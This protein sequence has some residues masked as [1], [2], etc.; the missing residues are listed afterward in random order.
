MADDFESLHQKLRQLWYPAALDAA[1]QKGLTLL[2]HAAGAGQRQAVKLL[3]QR[4]AAVA[5][6]GPGGVTALHCAAGAGDAACVQLLLAGGAD[7]LGK[8]NAGRT[9]LQ[10]AQLLGHK[11]AAGP[12]REAV[13]QRI[14][15]SALPAITATGGA[16]PG[17]GVQVGPAPAAG[18]AARPGTGTVTARSAAA[19]AGA[20]P[21]P[22]AGSGYGYSAA[23]AR[24]PPGPASSAGAA[25]VASIGAPDAPSSARLGAPLGAASR[26]SAS[27]EWQAGLR[28]PRVSLASPADAPGGGGAGGQGGVAVEG[29]SRT[30]SIFSAGGAAAAGSVHSARA[31]SGAASVPTGGSARPA[32]GTRAGPNASGGTAGLL[33]QLQRRSSSGSARTAAAAPKAGTNLQVHLCCPITGKPMRDPVT[34]ADG[35]TYERAAI[36]AWFAKERAAGRKPRSPLTD[37]PL[38]STTL[39]PNHL[40]RSLAAT[41]ERSARG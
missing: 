19:A 33:A 31:A 37:E 32:T 23:G 30:P 1:D 25:S 18:P 21:V 5:L 3:L 11:E 40:V 8:D 14:F 13:A 39:R 6:K 38:G 24:S 35:H 4:G 12:L 41:V 34:A 15:G 29:R 22:G 27:V 20:A 36:E 16:A 9:A 2:M 17:G 28:R 7:I 10:V 26:S